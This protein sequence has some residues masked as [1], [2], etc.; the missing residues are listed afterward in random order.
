MRG[1]LPQPGSS[2]WRAPGFGIRLT[3]VAGQT[4]GAVGENRA[5]D[6]SLTKGL[7]QTIFGC[8]FQWL[9]GVGLELHR[10]C[11]ADLAANRRARNLRRRY[12]TWY[13]LP[14]VQFCG[15]DVVDYAH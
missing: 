14:P 2:R 6:L 1:F 8:N 10:L 4:N 5:H 3:R 12:T 7:A 15:P 13:R 11:T 9:N